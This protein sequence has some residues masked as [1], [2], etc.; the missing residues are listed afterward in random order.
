MKNKRNKNSEQA[1]ENKQA[2]TADDQVVF[3][4]TPAGQ[5]ARDRWARRYDDLNGA[6]EGPDD[7]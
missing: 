1:D 4:E 3:S 2:E 7:Y 5:S 6:P